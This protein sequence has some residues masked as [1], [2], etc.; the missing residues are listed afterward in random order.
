[1]RPGTW[2]RATFT[3]SMNPYWCCCRRLPRSLPSRTTIW[4]IPHSCHRQAVRQGSCKASTPACHPCLVYDSQSTFIKG[5]SI[6]DNFRFVQPL[7]KLL[8]AKKHS[9]RLLKVDIACAFHSAVWAFLLE[10]MQQVSF[11][12]AS[13]NWTFLLLSPVSTRVMLN[14]V[15]VARVCHG[16][17]LR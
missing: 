4:Y 5:R 14:V 6:Q 9:T 10:I 1:M 13:L 16:R 15:P 7:A 2:T 3:Q 17:G 11:T 12:N 8:H